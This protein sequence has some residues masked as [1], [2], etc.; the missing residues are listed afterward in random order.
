MQSR[1]V[2]RLFAV[3][4]VIAV[5]VSSGC[6]RSAAPHVTLPPAPAKDAPKAER[7]A[8]V[9]KYRAETVG[10]DHVVLADGTRVEHPEDLRPAL[11]GETA[12]AEAVAA[13][14]VF[15]T[16]STQLAVWVPLA[17]VGAA[18]TTVVALFSFVWWVP[19][20]RNGSIPGGAVLPLWMSAFGGSMATFMLLAGGG[21]V[22]T[23]A[24][25]VYAVRFRRL[26]LL[27]FNR[28]LTQ[29]NEEVPAVRPTAAN[30]TLVDDD[31]AF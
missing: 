21:G 14:E 9:D 6:I 4:V 3:V 20:S 17:T 23:L 19:L 8:Y 18:A 29:H 7:Q 22:A 27:R 30:G 12:A 10:D 16:L 26:A 5:I 11:S 2:L 31:V 1:F 13:Y 15:A 24:S 28:G 25:W